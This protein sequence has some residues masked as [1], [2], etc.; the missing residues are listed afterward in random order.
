MKRLLIRSAFALN[1][2]MLL[3]AF[4]ALSQETKTEKVLIGIGAQYNLPARYFNTGIDKFDGRN[5]GI[6]FYV[7]PKLLKGKFLLGMKAEY[8]MVQE[9]FQT[10]AIRTYSLVSLS[11]TFKYLFLN[12]QN[13]P[14]I[15]FGT[16]LYYISFVGND[17]N[18]GIEPSAGYIFHKVQLSLNYNRI[19]NEVDYKFGKG[20][21][22]YYLALKL[23]VEL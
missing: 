9:I 4:P 23:G 2:A 3:L 13:T 21:G 18:W 5:S 1:F 11:P 8:A 17:L 15:G 12:R 20:F 22:N 10:D 16:G 6:G 7:E 14:Y 19:L